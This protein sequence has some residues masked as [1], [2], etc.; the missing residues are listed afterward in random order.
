MSPRSEAGASHSDGQVWGQKLLAEGSGEAVRTRGPR[1]TQGCCSARAITMNQGWAVRR[2]ATPPVKARVPCAVSGPETSFGC[3]QWLRG[4]RSPGGRVSTL[5]L[6]RPKPH[7]S[8]RPSGNHTPGSTRTQSAGGTV[9]TVPV[10]QVTRGAGRTLVP[11][12][13]RAC[14]PPP[15]PC[16][17][18]PL[19]HLIPPPPS[20]WQDVG[21]RGG[22]VL[23]PGTAG[24]PP[25]A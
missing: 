11:A 24:R 16:A 21:S 20:R 8:Y 4:G 15:A 6:K 13:R 2:P 12:G 17:C 19:G 3:D 22:H 18:V 14:P 1:G 23:L 7:P 25:S 5:R 9:T 10:E